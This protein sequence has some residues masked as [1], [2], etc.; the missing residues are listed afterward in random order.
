MSFAPQR[1]PALPG[2]NSKLMLENARPR[3]GKIVVGL[4]GH[5]E[6][7]GSDREVGCPGRDAWGQPNTG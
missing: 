3:Y 5:Q 4:V 2:G 1:G 7:H 6:T